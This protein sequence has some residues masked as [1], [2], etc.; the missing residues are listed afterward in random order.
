MWY[1]ILYDIYI[2][3][4]IF[5]YLFKGKGDQQVTAVQPATGQGSLSPGQARFQA[6]L[7]RVRAKEAAG[8]KWVGWGAYILVCTFVAAIHRKTSGSLSNK[9]K[10]KL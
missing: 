10:H 8:A 4:Y 3:I 2:Y 6:I 9:N 5:I 7:A 1:I